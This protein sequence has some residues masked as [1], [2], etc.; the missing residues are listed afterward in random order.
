MTRAQVMGGSLA[1]LLGGGAIVALSIGI[2][3]TFGLFLPPMTE[4]LGWGRETFAAAIAVQNLVWGATQP[5]FGAAADRWGSRRVVI[6]SAALYA[7]GLYLMATTSG[8]GQLFLSTGLLIGLALS[9]TSFAVVLGAV[10][11]AFPPQSRSM[12]LGLVSAGGSFGQFAMV[13]LGQA[14]IAGYGWSTALML[15]AVLALAMALLA[16]S[17]GGRPDAAPAAGEVEPAASIGAALREAGGHRGYRLLV[18]G[19]FVCGFHITFI[20]TH[21]PAYFADRG[22]QPTQAATA[23]ALIGLFNIVG[24]AL[25][26]YCGGHFAKK[27][28]LSLLYLARA[29]VILAMLLVPLTP[30]AAYAFAAAMGLL[31]LGT[32]PLT[33]ALVAQVFGPRYVGT[34]FGVV[35]F[36]HQIGAAL[37]VWLGGLVFD[38]TG[39]Y[40][41]VWWLAI[42]LGL[43]AAAL[44]MPI[45]ERPLVRV[46]RSAE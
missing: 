42:A 32:V 22:L 2:R 37:G 20:G 18:A 31:W 24:S 45:D 6:A 34:L 27:N 23:L 10:S 3:Q 19:F 21:L 17:L 35:F 8:S 38:A 43:L 26:G 28:V 9:G 7:V 25:C 5:I 12:A 39:S 33:N 36:S 13:P 30:L 15:I 41:I 16:G 1:V 29:G 40:D 14:F 4:D 11:R 46:A 44:H